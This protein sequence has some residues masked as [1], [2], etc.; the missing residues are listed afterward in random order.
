MAIAAAAIIVP[1]RQFFFV[2]DLFVNL[3][4]FRWS[5]GWHG[6]RPSLLLPFIVR[7]YGDLILMDLSGDPSHGSLTKIL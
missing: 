7:I 3:F 4:Q 5:F 2:P 1:L 6:K